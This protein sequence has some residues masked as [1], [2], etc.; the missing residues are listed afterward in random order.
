MAPMRLRLLA[1]LPSF[2]ILPNELCSASIQ[3]NTRIYKTPG[4]LVPQPF[5]R[6]RLHDLDTVQGAWANGSGDIQRTRYFR[7]ETAFHSVEDRRGDHYANLMSKTGQ[8]A[9]QP[10]P[11]D[12]A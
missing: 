12:V 5:E 10:S 6:R 9:P 2:T 11:R 3:S 1:Y 7:I 4:Q 8:V